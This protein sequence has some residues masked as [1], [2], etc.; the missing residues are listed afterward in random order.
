M[1]VGF[2][3]DIYG[4]CG[5]HSCP[6][7]ANESSCWSMVE[8]DYKFYLSFENSLCKDYVTEKFFNALAVDVIPVVLGGADY[9]SL[10]PPMSY[11]SVHEPEHAN[12]P[13]ALA[14]T[15]K[16]LATSPE[17]YAEYFWWK[18]YYEVVTGPF[19]RAQTFCDIC[20]RLHATDAGTS[21]YEDLALIH[22]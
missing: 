12:D 6:R 4:G 22:I 8:R 21:V 9:A 20:Q 19:E 17:R 14:R 11:V 16:A 10:A 5:T 18:D 1:I 15:L 13:G 3:V 7:G 2:Q